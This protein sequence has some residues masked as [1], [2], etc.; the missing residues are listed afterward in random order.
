M[1]I[2]SFSLRLKPMCLMISGETVFNLV[3]HICLILSEICKQFLI[4]LLKFFRLEVAQMLLVMNFCGQ[5]K[6]LLPTEFVIKQPAWLLLT[7]GP[8][9]VITVPQHLCAF[10]T[11]CLKPMWHQLPVVS[12]KHYKPTNWFYTSGEV[13]IKKY[14]FKPGKIYI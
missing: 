10:S 14:F 6:W 3:A 11:Y 5:V 1:K 9:V 2:Y 13:N 12:S 4:W 8:F 7:R